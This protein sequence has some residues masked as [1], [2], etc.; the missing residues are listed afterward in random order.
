MKCSMVSPT[1]LKRSLVLPVLIFSSISFHCSHKKAFL[2]LFASLWNSPFSWEYLSISPLRLLLFFSQ[3]FLRP[4]QTK[5][6][7]SCISFSLGWFWSLVL[8]EGYKL[9]VIV[10]QTLYLPSI[11]PWIYLSPP[12]YNHKG[13]DLGHTE[14]P[15]GFSLLSSI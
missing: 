8:V 1:F 3:L 13:F 5:I 14:W 2:S 15:G 11:I 6:F 7:P 10:L 9:L 4:P 12:L